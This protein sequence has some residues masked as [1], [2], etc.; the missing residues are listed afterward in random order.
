MTMESLHCVGVQKRTYGSNAP[1]YTKTTKFAPIKEG[2]EYAGMLGPPSEAPVACHKRPS[3]WYA[4]KPDPVSVTMVEPF[5]ETADGEIALMTG[6]A[7]VAACESFESE[8]RPPEKTNTCT[9]PCHGGAVKTTACPE[10][11]TAPDQDVTAQ[12]SAGTC[13]QKSPL[14]D[15]VFRITVPPRDRL[16]IANCP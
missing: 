7:Y 13:C 16:L 15:M 4:P 2:A 12:G 10:P 1:G 8:Y 11:T 5:V 6:G 14:S 3:V 9:L